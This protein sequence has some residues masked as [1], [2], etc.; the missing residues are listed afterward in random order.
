MAPSTSVVSRPLFELVHAFVLQTLTF[1]VVVA[2]FVLWL[3]R[4]AREAPA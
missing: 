1:I 4:T 2:I 3:E